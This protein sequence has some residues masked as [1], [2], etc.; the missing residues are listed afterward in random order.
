MGSYDLMKSV[1]NY[2]KKE[3]VLCISLLLAF[4]SMAFVPLDNK[5]ISYIDFHTLTIL[6]SLMIVMAGQCAKIHPQPFGAA[7]S[8]GMVKEYSCGW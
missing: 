1:L 6:L 2:I 3:A 8:E 4:A 7:S 5:Y